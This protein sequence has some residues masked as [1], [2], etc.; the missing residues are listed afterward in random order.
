MYSHGRG[1]R[2]RLSGSETTEG[3]P[4]AALYEFRRRAYLHFCGL[5]FLRTQRA[6]S[7]EIH[8]PSG[9]VPNSRS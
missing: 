1:P 8:V 6:A 7:A 5:Q 9:G 2:A 3:R 4:Q